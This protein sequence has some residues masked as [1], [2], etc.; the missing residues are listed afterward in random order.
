LLQRAAVTIADA[1]PNDPFRLAFL[2]LRQQQQLYREAANDITFLTPTLYSASIPL[3]AEA[4]VGDYAIDV[5]LFVDGAPIARTNS[6]FEVYKSGMEQ[7][8]TTAA[9]D[10]GLLYGLAT[11]MMALVTGWF[12]SVVF[13]RD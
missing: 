4:P 13:R 5:R 12:A 9:R 6:A 3:P 11:A 7:L 10:H 8:L 1:A 2:K